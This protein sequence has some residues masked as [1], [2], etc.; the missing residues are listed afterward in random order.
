MTYEE[1]AASLSRDEIVTLLATHDKLT[2]EVTELRRQLDWLKRQLFGPKSER[3]LPDPSNA[4]QL[5]LGAAVG[6]PATNPPTITIQGHAR[7]ATKS[8]WE[9][10]SDSRLRFDPSVPVREILV[11]NPDADL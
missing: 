7:H 11:P 2:T 1:K 8:K 6:V 10:T 4:E 9:G 3:R 5:A